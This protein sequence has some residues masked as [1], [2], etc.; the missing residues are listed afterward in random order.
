VIAVFNPSMKIFISH[1]EK[2]KDIVDLFVDLLQTGADMQRTD[3]FCSLRWSRNSGAHRL[4]IRYKRIVY[5][6]NN[7]H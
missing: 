1:S 7:R 2:D 5:F 3:I 4:S 6:L